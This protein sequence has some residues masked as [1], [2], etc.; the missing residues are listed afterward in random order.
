MD[1]EEIG[2]YIADN[3]NSPKAALNTVNK[4]QD[5]IDNLSAFPLMGTSLSSIV[6]I[7]TDYR[8]LICGNYLAFYRSFEDYV[9]IDRILYAGRDYLSI[10]FRDLPQTEI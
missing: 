7:D 6:D 10:F 2:D 1:L 4:I 5:S 8:F 9:Y 3:L